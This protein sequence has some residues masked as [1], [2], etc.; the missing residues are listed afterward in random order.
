MQ[1]QV[2]MRVLHRV[3]D[4]Q[5]ERDALLQRGVGAR[6]VFR[7]RL[8]LQV[9]HHEVRAVVE[10]AAIQQPRDV[11]MLQARENLALRVEAAQH[12][13]GVHAVL[14]HLDRGALLELPVVAL[15][16]VDRAH[17]AAADFAHHAPRAQPLRRA[18][19]LQKSGPRLIAAQQGFHIAAHIG[20]T[21]AL[22]LDECGAPAGFDF[23]RVAHNLFDTFPPVR[24]HESSRRSQSRA[25]FQSRFTVAGD[26]SSTAAASSIVSPPNTRNSTIRDWR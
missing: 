11:R 25:T 20:V 19:E 10:H 6:A 24:G 12:G 21:G 8:A 9:L 23:E 16:E 14:D 1:H 4:L 2:A 13:L 22:P 7:E 3:A 15:G 5:E 17:P 18:I 26:S